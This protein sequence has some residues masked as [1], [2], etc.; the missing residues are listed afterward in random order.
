VRPSAAVEARD[1]VGGLE[2][3]RGARG[4]EEARLV[5]IDH[6]QDLDLVATGEA[7]V[8]DVGLPSLIRLVGLEPNEGVHTGSL[9]K[10]LSTQP[11]S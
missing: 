3:Q 5:V 7:L 11:N 9:R 2:H 1:N 4:D 10:L 8:R 6:V